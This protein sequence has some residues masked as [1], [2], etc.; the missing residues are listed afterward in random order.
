MTAST[1]DR[2]WDYALGHLSADESSE[3]AAAIQ[4]SPE[5]AAELAETEALMHALAEGLP[6]VAP[7][8]SVRDRLMASIDDEAER[9]APF[10][11]SLQKIFDLGRDAM[12]DVLERAKDAAQWE[13]GPYPGTQLFHFDGGPA[14]A[15]ADCGLVR[16]PAGFVHPY[17]EHL[18]RESVLILSGSHTESDG[19]V[20]RPGDVLIKEAGTGHAYTVAESAPYVFAIALEIGIEVFPEGKGGPS[21]IVHAETKADDPTS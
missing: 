21:V 19:T 3:V 13:A 10:L 7:P 17:H 14:T 4:Q 8:P 18:G 11:S 12:R 6:Q 9:Y 1:R 5:L 20:A 2:L 15:L 16:F